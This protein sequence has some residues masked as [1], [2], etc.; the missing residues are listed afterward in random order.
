MTFVEKGNGLI[1]CGPKE[2]EVRSESWNED[3]LSVSKES[4]LNGQNCLKWS[5]LF[6]EVASTLWWK[7]IHQ[8][9][10]WEED[11]SSEH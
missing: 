11:L 9:G 4:I 5:G 3:I 7:V 6:Y 10:I 2:L 8:S 1:L